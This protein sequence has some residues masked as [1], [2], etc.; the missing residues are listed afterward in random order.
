[1]P[2]TTSPCF[3]V[4]ASDGTIYGVAATTKRDALVFAHHR[5][6]GDGSTASPVSAERVGTWPAVMGT[7]LAY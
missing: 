6:V 2:T 1:M 4:H 3:H 5:L 7:V